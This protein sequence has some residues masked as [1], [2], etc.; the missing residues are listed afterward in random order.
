ML[1]PEQSRAARGWL[2]WSQDDLAKRAQV[3]LSTIRD[4]EKARRIPIAN[5]L[6]AIQRALEAAGVSIE[7]ANG[8]VFNP[9]NG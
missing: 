4:F 9:N 8:I 7:N 5:N 6:Q 2:D 1:S 3:S